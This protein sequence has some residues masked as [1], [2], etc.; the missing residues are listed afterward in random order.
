MENKE[1][2]KYFRDQKI[3]AIDPGKSGGI[4]IYSLTRNIIIEVAKMPETMK[5]LLT[6]LKIYSKESTC[7]LEMVGGRPGMGGSRMFNFGQQ[8]GHIEMALL[9]L[10]IPTTEV[11]PQKWLKHYQMGVKGNMTGVEWKNKLKSKAQ[12]LFPSIKVTLDISD[13]LLIMEYARFLTQQ[14]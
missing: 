7:V 14:K 5:D 10:E 6:F 8:F 11:T 12:Q 2:V 13:A 4:A 9:A 1:R 3:I